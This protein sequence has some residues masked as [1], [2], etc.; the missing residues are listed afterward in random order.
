MTAPDERPPPSRLGRREL[1]PML[2]DDGADDGPLFARVLLGSALALMGAG[3]AWSLYRRT[4]RGADLPQAVDDALEAGGVANPVTAVLLSFRAYDT[5]LE[6]AV[7][8]VV[9]V[10]VWSLDRGTR[11]F[12]RASGTADEEPVL[13]ALVRI[14]APL[15]FLTAVYL[16][17]VG[18]A[19]PGGAFQAGALAAGAGVLLSTS[20]HL[21][22]PTAASQTT[23]A[24]IAVGLLAFVVVA[25]APL[26]W[27]GALLAHPEGWAGVMILGLELL[28]AVSITTVLVELFIDVPAVPDPDRSLAGVHPTGDPLGRALANPLA[29]SEPSTRRDRE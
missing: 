16:V 18:S 9:M 6:V 23:R 7:L 25:V 24:A 26:P 13:T 8:V 12:G 15:I 10:G 29:T 2:H 4:P 20:G 11:R 21:R 5:L 17:W 14:V 28:L 22:P 27:T 1:E 19:R 3:L